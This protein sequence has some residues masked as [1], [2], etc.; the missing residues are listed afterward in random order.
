MNW[1]LC[2][3]F[4]KTKSQNTIKEYSEHKSG[5]LNALFDGLTYNTRRHFAPGANTT[6]LEK[7]DYKLC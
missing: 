5:I 2:D 1:R 3:V 4:K 6:Q 7:Y